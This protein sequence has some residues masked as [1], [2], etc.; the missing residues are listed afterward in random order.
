[1][2]VATLD[3]YIAAA[4]QRVI[5]NKSGATR[6]L[7]TLTWGTMFDL[8]GNPGAGTLAG[9]STAA[10]VVPT[11]ATAGFPVINAFGGSATGYLATIDFGSTVPGRFALYDM[12]FKAGAYAFNAATTLA[13][14]PSYS[15][16][17]PS[18]TDYGGTEIWFECVTAF[19]GNP[20]VTV[21]YTNQAGVA[22]H[23][24]GAVAFGVAPGV[25][26]RI[27]L[28][29]AAGDTGVQKI[30]SVTATVA[31]VGTFNVLVLRPLWTGRVKIANDG[32]I[33]GMDKTG[34]PVVYA[35]SALDVAFSPDGTNTGV[36]ELAF[37]IANA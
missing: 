25:G 27:Q 13:A 14:Q 32:D 18:G 24:T 29:L 35:T 16:R 19:T 2:A 37:T 31:T 17:V 33:H 11:S 4:K 9:S 22:A 3:Q 28:P 1:M 10:G 36:P 7:T 34:T 20:T 6:N 21:T 23:T 8:G 5:W 30:E 12:L 15:A 26:R